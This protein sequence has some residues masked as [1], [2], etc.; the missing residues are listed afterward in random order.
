MA[1]L[2]DAEIEAALGRGEYAHKTEPRAISVRF[3]RRTRDVVVKLRNGAIA[4]IP[5]RLLQGLD[6]ATERQLAEVE[7]QQDG[8]GLRWPSLDIDLSVPGLLAGIFGTQVHMAKLA[9]Q[10]KSAAKAAAARRNG[11]KGGRPRKKAT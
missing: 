4:R 9:G 7:M 5:A 6:K 3:D 2:T 8:Y 1:E 10:T 11:S